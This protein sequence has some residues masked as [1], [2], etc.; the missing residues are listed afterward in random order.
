MRILLFLPLLLRLLTLLL[1][2]TI[3]FTISFAF[4]VTI[5]ITLTITSNVTI[6]I[7]ININIPSRG[8]SYTGT[9]AITKIATLSRY[10]DNRIFIILHHIILYNFVPH[11]ITIVRYR[12]LFVLSSKMFYLDSSRSFLFCS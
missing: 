12:Y 8:L 1:N 3:T 2:I 4:A 9:F 6:T 11:Y 5:K 7:T 10:H